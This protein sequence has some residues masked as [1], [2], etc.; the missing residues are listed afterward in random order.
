MPIER[1]RPKPDAFNHAAALPF[2]LRIEDFSL[3]L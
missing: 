3:A 2:E 1:Q